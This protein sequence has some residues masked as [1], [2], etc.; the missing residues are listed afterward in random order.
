MLGKSNTYKQMPAGLWGVAE[1]HVTQLALPRIRQEIKHNQLPDRFIPGAMAPPLSSTPGTLGGRATGVALLS[2]YPCRALTHTWP[3]HIWDSGRIVAGAAYLGS[4]WVKAGV[5]YGYA[6]NP[7]LPS[8]Q[9]QTDEILS[10][11]T[12]RIVF[13]SCGMRA[14]LGDFNHSQDKLPQFSR[15]RDAGFMEI[16]DFAWTKW[17]I[18]PKPTCKGSTRVDMV[19]LSPELLKHVVAVTVDDTWYADHSVVF[20]ELS[21]FPS[22]EP[23]PVWRMPLKLPWDQVQSDQLPCPEV[24]PDGPTFDEVFSLVEGAVD[25]HLRS[26]EHTGL[27]PQQKGRCT[28]MAPSIKPHAVVPL[29]QSR[30]TD[31]QVEF[32]G[33]HFQHT[34]WCRQLRRLQS[35][36]RAAA[37]P[38]TPTHQEQLVGAWKAIRAA[39]GFPQGFPQAWAH[40]CHRSAGSPVFLP[41]QPPDAQIASFILA[42]FQVVFRQLEKAL[43]Q[44]RVEAARA[45]RA[46]DSNVVFSDVRK[47]R[48]MPAQTIVQN[49]VADV[50]EVNLTLK[51]IS[52]DPPH[53]ALDE[54]IRCKHGFLLPSEH[55]PGRITLPSEPDVDVGDT[56]FQAKPVGNRAQVFQ[57]FRDMWH[58]LWNKHVDTP[59][60]DWYPFQE[61]LHS[62]FPDNLPDLHLPPLTADMWLSS[63]QGKKPRSATGP[64]GISRADLLALPSWATALIVQ[65]LT[66]IE[67]GDASWDQSVLF[68]HITAIEKN[69]RAA[70]PADYRPICVLSMLY[71]CW[72]SLRARDLLRHLDRYA[73][74]SLIGNRPG[75]STSDMWWQLAS[76]L[77]DVQNSDDKQLCGLVT[78][79]TKCFNTIP[80]PVVYLVARKLGVPQQ[81]LRCWFQ[82]INRTQRMFIIE[83]ACSPPI[84]GCT[85]FPEGDALSVFAMAAVNIA[86]H[87]ITNAKITPGVVYSYVDNWEMITSDPH[88][89]LNANHQFQHFATLVDLTLDEAK[90]YAW[91]TDGHAR[92]IL[93]Q[94]GLTVKLDAKDLGGHMQYCKRNSMYTIRSRFRA[95]ED[96]WHWI[97]RSVAPMQQKLKVIQ[98]VAWPRCLYGVSIVTVGKA[99][100]AKLRA[101]A[102][103]SLGWNKKGANSAIQ[104]ALVLPPKFDPECLA[105][106][107]SIRAFRLHAD[108]GIAYGVLDTLTGDPPKRFRPGPCAVLLDRLHQLGWRWEGNGYVTDH[109]GSPLHLLED[110]VQLLQLRFFQAWSIKVGQE[111]DSRDTFQGLAWV[112]R[113]FTM[114]NH[115]TWTDE[116]AS[117]L[118]TSMNGTFYT[119]DKQIHNGKVNTIKCPWC[120]ADDSLYHRIWEC[121]HFADL[122]RT[123][124][125]DDQEA[126]MSLGPS[127]YLHGW[128]PVL[129]AVVHFAQALAACPEPQ[130]V[131]HG[132][133]PAQEPWQLFSDGACQHPTKPAIRLATWAVTVAELTCDEFVPLANGLLPGRL[134]TTLRA[135]IYAA[136]VAIQAATQCHK[137]FMLWTD[138]QLVHDRLVAWLKGTGKSIGALTKDSDLWIRLRNAAHLARNKGLFLHVVKVRSHQDE[139]AYPEAIEAWAIRGNASADRLATEALQLMP[140]SVWYPWTQACAQ[141]AEFE[142]L[143]DHMHRLLVSIG[144]RAVAEK[145]LTRASAAEAA[146]VEFFKP[147]VTDDRVSVAPLPR[148]VAQLPHCRGLEHVKSTVLEWLWAFQGGRDNASSKNMWICGYQLIAHFQL[149]TRTSWISERPPELFAYF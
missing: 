56:L 28:T 18:P 64:D 39:K 73:P 81:L 99:N 47:P 34:Q 27:L 110:P 109:W 70:T 105:A 72:S 129:P 40:R 43:I 66:A 1:T 55:E 128:F 38:I 19:W 120:C 135:E 137:K 83:G 90:S 115:R 98:A 148:D 12:D 79:V 6:H 54:P 117:L 124:P 100:F 10:C 65:R 144:S 91:A 77:E 63:A 108:P 33:E 114:A 32:H 88:E 134:H 62:V 142:R 131:L 23:I 13:Q 3:G 118:R 5:A 84:E 20:A 69:D 61:A 123:I 26:R 52:Y 21:E 16:Q 104:F 82:A 14:I 7:H 102:M 46:A 87:A 127:T 141:L 149:H 113:D 94:G 60:D 24:C 92:K 112:D 107:D 140:A 95:C 35:Y 48:S 45:R 116:Q 78:D 11:L 44:K 76:L 74:C 146:Q 29:K 49:L 126:L 50:V 41:K 89:V 119:R 147:T 106:W 31:I 96:L 143:R 85:G 133:Y 121:E 97:R 80:R 136:L 2:R 101:A 138:N 103:A 145:H 25:H 111:W 58:P 4:Q 68:G 36:S 75:R 17:K 9:Q 8:T 130:V 93:K 57:A 42:D 67:R 132:P 37:A 125:L 59:V 86:F 71:R 15:W 51:Q 22:P 30:R 122:R 53:F 139:K